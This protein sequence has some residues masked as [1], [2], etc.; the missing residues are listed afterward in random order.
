MVDVLDRSTKRFFK[1]FLLLSF[2]M[3]LKIEHKIYV[4]F[5]EIQDMENN[6][7]SFLIPSFSTKLPKKWHLSDIFSFFLLLLLTN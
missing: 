4:W 2:F 7:N 5:F 6:S 3:F 1:E